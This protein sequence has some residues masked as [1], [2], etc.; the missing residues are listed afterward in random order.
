MDDLVGTVEIAA[1]LD[2]SHVANVHAWRKRNIGFPAPIAKVS[3]TYLWDWTDVERW[4]RRTGRLP[5]SD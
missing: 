3:G 2:Q 1:R 4:A 5:E